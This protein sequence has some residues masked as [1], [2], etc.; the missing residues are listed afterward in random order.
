MGAGGKGVKG[1]KGCRVPG[2]ESGWGVGEGALACEGLA[3]EAAGTAQP[4]L[5]AGLRKVS[6]LTSQPEV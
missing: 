6:R 3:Y 1:M 5:S 4:G 2:R